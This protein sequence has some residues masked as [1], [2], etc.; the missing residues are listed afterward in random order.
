MKRTAILLLAAAI[1]LSG[2]VVY[3]D[4]DGYNRGGFRSGISY[5]N[6]VYYNN[7]VAYNHDYYYRT[8]DA[9]RRMNERQ[10]AVFIRE[11]Q[12]RLERQRL[13]QQREQNRRR[14]EQVRQQNE[15]QREQMQHVNAPNSSA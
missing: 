1:G 15:R 2:C 5:D 6:G 8:N 11:Q 14:T 9:Y 13:N 7:G 3:D 10:R 12:Q 4:Y